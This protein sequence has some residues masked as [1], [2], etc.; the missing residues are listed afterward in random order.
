MTLEA[1]RFFEGRA[2]RK[3]AGRRAHAAWAPAMDRADPVATIERMDRGRIPELVPIRHWRMMQSPFAFYRG[4][5]AIMAA[6]LASTPATG[7]RVQACGDA[8]L[9]NFGAFATPERN[10]FFDVNDFD[11]TLPG[12]WEWD[13]KRLTTSFVLAARNNGIAERA[14]GDAALAAAESYR[15]SMRTLAAMTALEV[16]YSRV[17]VRDVIAAV[18]KTEQRRAIAKKAATARHHVVDSVFTKMTTVVDGRLQL[19]DAPPLVYHPTGDLGLLARNTAL[20]ERYRKTLRDDIRT[21]FDRYSVADAVVKAVGIGSVGTICGVAL[22]TAGPGDALLI[23]VKQAEAS[24][25]EPFAG[26]S[27]YENHAERVVTGQ[28][29][30]QAATDIF[31]GWTHDDEGRHFYF[32]QLRDMKI[33]L[34]IDGMP[35]SELIDYARLCGRALARAHARTGDPAAIAGYLGV[36][37]AFDRA[38]VGFARRYADQTEA[39][40]E[41]FVAA[42]KSGRLKAESDGTSEPSARSEASSRPANR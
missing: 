6:D 8:H 41:L 36:S 22:L 18:R 42:I 29:R 23:Q 7:L 11:E 25:L 2:L 33:T 39:D 15:Q 38:V 30:M 1:D 27:K 21:L 4:T 19:I 32:R 9:S 40:Y 28:R 37:N 34:S 5:A 26:P 3:T 12:P 13:L 16:W 17:D 31:L 35:P 24:V 10:I 20:I 14:C